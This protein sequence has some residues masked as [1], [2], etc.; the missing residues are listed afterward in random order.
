MKLTRGLASREAEAHA[1]LVGSQVVRA[2]RRAI[3]ELDA[4]QQ[5]EREIGIAP[6]ITLPNVAVSRRKPGRLAR[7]RAWFNGQVAVTTQSEKPRKM[8]QS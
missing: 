4:A 6:V 2:G 7:L 3:P 8:R 5:M 1:E